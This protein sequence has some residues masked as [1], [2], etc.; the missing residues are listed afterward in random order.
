VK[1]LR[2]CFSVKLLRVCFSVKLLHKDPNVSASINT[3]KCNMNNTGQS[4]STST[5]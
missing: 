5:V 2:V 3:I 4:A 1:L